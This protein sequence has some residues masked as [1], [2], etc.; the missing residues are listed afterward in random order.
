MYFFS[1]STLVS[2]ITQGI[3]SVWYRIK[4]RLL[5]ILLSAYGWVYFRNCPYWLSIGSCLTCK[6]PF[7]K[8]HWCIGVVGEL[9]QFDDVPVSSLW[10]GVGCGQV[11]NKTYYTSDSPLLS[12][13]TRHEPPCLHSQSLS[14][15]IT[16]IFPLENTM[17]KSVFGSQIPR[18]TRSIS[19]FGKI[20]RVWHWKNKSTFYLIYSG[21]RG[22]VRYF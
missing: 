2:L 8:V 22:F 20:C 10:Y 3:I 21:Y 16:N 9:P 13:I 17:N 15:Y 11:S 5:T 6:C 12:L 4:D 7:P 14:F 18:L 19:Q 1:Y